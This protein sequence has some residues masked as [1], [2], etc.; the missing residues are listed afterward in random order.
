M[1]TGH[2]SI[3]MCTRNRGQA[4][5]RC[6]ESV[7]RQD[8]PAASLEIAVLDDASSDETP[9]RVREA[10][11]GISAAGFS[12]AELFVNAEN[13]QIASGRSLLE[14][15]VSAEAEF[16]CFVDDDAE[17]PPETLSGLAGFLLKNPGVGA[18]G[19]RIAV[20]SAPGIP[21]H[22]A[23]F[24]SWAGRYTE[25]DSSEPLDC[26]WLNSTC[27]MVRVSALAQ[28]GGFYA[29][30]YTAHEEVDLCLRLKNKGWR[31]VYFPGITVLHDITP[32]QTKRDRL[33]YL[34]RNKFLVFKRN[35]GLFRTVAASLGT[36][37]FGLPKYLLESLRA[38]IDAREISLVLRAVIDGVHGREGRGH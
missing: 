30:F 36:L 22:M 38:G 28:S 2:I 35:F 31:V 21:V 19:P 24:V 23:N 5:V 9:L 32:G 27:L 37:V 12:R 20:M 11:S 15:K 17:L 4:V 29:G 34:Y 6:L 10:L 25:K 3:L 18:V 14:K 26:D 16:I 7:L 33:Y 8:Y 1:K 13:I